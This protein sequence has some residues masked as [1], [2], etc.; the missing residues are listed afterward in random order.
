M[1]V[2]SVIVVISGI[3]NRLNSLYRSIV[4][5]DAM[6]I[7]SGYINGFIFRYSLNVPA[8]VE[9]RMMIIVNSL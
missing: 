8:T 6:C 9:S 1:I 2:N 7:S 4:T 3:G 5:Y